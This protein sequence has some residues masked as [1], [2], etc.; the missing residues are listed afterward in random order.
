MH[1]MPTPEDFD[2]LKA[3][4][5]RYDLLDQERLVELRAEYHVSPPVPYD[6]RLGFSNLTASIESHSMIA[7]EIENDPNLSN[8]ERY[9]LKHELSDRHRQVVISQSGEGFND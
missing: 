6:E 9:V 3:S 4:I 1:H 2:E 7:A 8:E 5:A